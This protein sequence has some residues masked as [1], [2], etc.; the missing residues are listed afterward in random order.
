QRF[1]IRKYH[2]GAASVLLGMT[3]AF[4]TG[5]V[6][7]ADGETN[8]AGTTSENV[9][10]ASDG[11]SSAGTAEGT[12]GTTSDNTGSTETVAYSASPADGTTNPTVDE[13]V[14][15]FPTSESDPVPNG[16]VLVSFQKPEYGSYVFNNLPGEFPNAAKQSIN[17]RRIQLE[18]RFWVKEGTTWGQ[19]IEDPNWRWPTM[20]PND[21]DVFIDWNIG[22]GYSNR[23]DFN[24]K[25]DQPVTTTY[26][27]PVVGYEVEEVEPLNANV[28]AFLAWYSPEGKNKWLIVTFDAG[29]GSMTY[30]NKQYTSRSVA[31]YFQGI[32]YD[33]R[34]FTSKVVSPTLA[35][36]TF[37]RWQT[38][39]GKVLPKSGT[40][41]TETTYE[42]LYLAHPQ[43]KVAVFDSAKLT[44]SEKEQVKQNI[45]DANP[46]LS[47][48]VA[49]AI[50]AIDISDKGEATVT[51][52]DDTVVKV[53]S[54]TLTY[55]DKATAR[56]NAKA[57]I[58][59]EA[60]EKSDAI[61]AS[62]LTEEEKTARLTEVQ[63]AN[64]RANNAIDKAATTEDLTEAISDG[65]AAIKAVSTTNTIKTK[66]KQALEEAYNAKKD[67]IDNSSLTAEEKAEKQA[68][69]D[70]DKE[71]ATKSIDTATTDDSVH[72]ALTDGKSAITGID[73]STSTKKAQ[74]KQALEE[75]YNA[76]KDEIAKSALTAEE[77]VAKQA[78]LDQAKSAEDRAIDAATDNAGVDT[79]LEASKT[80]I[81]GIDTSTSA[82][83]VQ[84]KQDLETAYN[85]KK[86]EIDKSALTAEEKAA[87][88]A[89][90]DKAKEDADKAIDAATDASGVAKALEA[91]K[92]AIAGIDTSSSAKKA[93][94]K[95]DLER[96]YNAKKDEIAKSALTAE[97]KVA[98]QAELDQAKSAEDR[99]IAAATDNAGVDTALEA[100]K[101]AIAG[102]DT[103]T[104]A[105]KVQAKQDL[106]TAYNAKKEEIDK[107]ALTAEEK[108][109]K[110][111]E[112]DKAKED[113]DKA[114]DAATDASGVAKALEAGKTAI[115]G[116]DTSSSAK[117]AQAKKDLE[118]AYNAKKAEIAN[119]GLT[120]EEKAAKQAEL[121]KAKED[122]DKAIDVATD[123]S[124]VAKAL[125]D[126]KS[127]ID[128][129]NTTTSAE[130]AAAKKDLEAAY[131]AKKA[132]IANSG[133]TAEE[134]AAKQAELDKAKADADK[135]IDVATDASGVA[136][137][138]EAGKSAIAGIDTSSSAK[139]TAAKQDLEAAYNAKKDEIA[140]SALT[141]EEKATKLAELDKAKEDATKSIDTATTDDSVHKA[142]TEGKSTI[143]AIDTTASPKKTAAKQD[144]ETAYNAKKSEIENSAL[145]AEEKAAKQAELDK[146]KADAD[147]AIDVATDA[148][149][150][151]KALEAGKA[152]IDAINTTTSA[153]KAAA[154]KDLEAAYNAKQ[155]E[156]ENSALT[157]E[158]KAA[159]QVELDKAKED[160]DKAIDVATDA[161][162]VA[163]ALEAGKAT[164]DA[165][166]TTTSAEK[167]AAKEALEEAYNAKKAEIENSALTAEEKAA[168]QAE[169]DKAK[170]DAD[171]AI[172]VATDASGVAKALEAGKTA[173]AGI[174]TSSSAKKAQAK[175]DLEAAY[176]AKKDEIAKSALTAEEK[177]AKQAEL[178]KAKE[179]A[180]KA[181]DTAPDASGVARALEAGKTAI[182]GIDT[183]SSAKKAQAK[184]DLETAYNAKK[185]EIENSALTAEEKAAKQAELDKA[186]ADADKAIDTAPDASGVA[187]ALE[188]GKSA[189]AG[190]DTSSSAKKAQ[191]KQDLEAAYNAKKDEIA[192]SALTAEEKAAK[193]AELD[194]AKEDA[195]KAIDTAPDASGVARA[196]EAGK[197][198]IAGIDTSSSA[199]KAQAKQD[200]ET[201]YNAKKA[202][203]E[204]SALTAEE[205]AAKQ[206]ELDKAK[207][208]ADKAI[209]TAPDA[210]GVAKALED[211]KSA[212][213]AINTITSAEKAA[214]K[215]A[216]EEAYNAKQAEI[217]NSALTAEE[218]AAKQVELDKAKEDA[219]K[220]IDVATDA[221]G[222][223]KALEAGKA[224]IDAINTTTSAEKAAAKKDLEAAYNAKKAEIA[225]SGLTAEE[226]AA[227]QAE[228]DKAKEDADKAIDVATDASGVAKAL[229][230]GKATIDAIN[231]TTSA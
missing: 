102:I 38:Q 132:E 48:G 158:E 14:I 34:Q 190:I 230:A 98:K 103:S 99:A 209:D 57:E 131:N 20:K 1:S 91:G 55:E 154:K 191:A 153:E 41:T 95:Q 12:A 53:S 90:L 183:S 139:K 208:D 146:A 67:E 107:S 133:L 130:K 211:G 97:E 147:K 81:A 210:S 136:K 4:G 117:K 93:Q 35:N 176:N 120:A 61:E 123:A 59:K 106:E 215:Q 143:A 66:A 149:G 6:V 3:L 226:K 50:K 7:N 217:E 79:A 198:A 104:S 21:G 195:D 172:D 141:A 31:A 231:T 83:K 197:T 228:L 74:A 108:A 175:Q 124:G 156:I 194:K 202:E 85:A 23:F 22:Y 148:S 13:S 42:A 112:L 73:T 122:A 82:K 28:N 101:T 152:T 186:K 161:S 87:K 54:A 178:D 18:V 218:K 206:A 134:K 24:K 145:T 207:A 121:D 165:I 177:A 113:A 92:T 137:A 221:S 78:E 10:P 76:K 188:D 220:A 111:A 86:E 187:K 33:N 77:K 46:N 193:Q 25:K 51:F 203:I 5:V 223:A 96:A 58:E 138:L 60:T 129:I 227:K 142:L 182:A 2:I 184:Q 52:D 94:A 157:A 205:K 84:A 159:K 8:T 160:A 110:Q 80:A 163:K 126:G 216:L 119:S 69:L 199:K 11:T 140:K 192:K 26:F 150:V 27:F 44:T 45:Y 200:L 16:Y 29:K 17:G 65:T 15:K 225:N 43:N 135:A 213:D 72:K 40:I 127:T 118:A 62:N 155:A 219:D 116:I 222:V 170:A 88:Q 162:G 169:L 174:D 185:A 204:N 9:Q 30:K 71:E 212:I 36:H 167:A 166:N 70:K 171:K 109:A 196:L 63:D 19:L 125:E 64:D 189:I 229:E 224:T 173:I 56:S 32:G 105:K 68:E 179:D 75:A 144:L 89:E 180:D 114:I 168:K 214:A 181:I 164:I 115:A 49:S 100:S 128:A 151:A 39:D 47:T 201:A 37:V